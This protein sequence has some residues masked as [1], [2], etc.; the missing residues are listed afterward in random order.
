MNDKNSF[1]NEAIAALSNLTRLEVN[2]LV[3]N[4][5]FNTSGKDSDG[6]PNNT[7]I[8]NDGTGERM[9]SQINLITGDITTAMTDKFVDEYKELREYHLIRE[10]QGHEIIRRNIAVLK[11]ILD[12]LNLFEKE[13]GA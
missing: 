2:T 1:L 9:C 11:E 3:G 7:T 10:S 4:Y 8:K 12:A 13:K 6:N 5:T